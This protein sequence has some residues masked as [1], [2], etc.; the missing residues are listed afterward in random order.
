[1]PDTNLFL[2]FI[3][4]VVQFTAW[5]TTRLYFRHIVVLNAH[6]LNAEGPLIVICNHPNTLIDPLLAVPQL[7]ERP[8]LLANYSMFKHPI[9]R[10]IFSTLFCIPVQRTKDIPA[11]QTPK[12]DEAFRRSVDYLYAGGSVFLAP[13]SLSENGRQ[14]RPFKSGVSRIV[15]TALS[16]WKDDAPPL[17][18]LPVGLTYFNHKKPNTDVIINVGAPIDI[19][20]ETENLPEQYKKAVD[21]LTLI[22][23]NK[24]RPLVIDCAD[25][26]EDNF[27]KKVEC[28]LQN[29]NQVSTKEKFFRSQKFLENFSEK[30]IEKNNFGNIFH[31][32][33]KFEKYFSLLEALH[34][35]DVN[36]KNFS[37]IK[38][39][40]ILVFG[41]PVFVLGFLNNIIP[42]SLATFIKNRMN[43]EDYETTIQYVAGLVLFPI[44]WW[45][46]SVIFSWFFYHP[47][48][49]LIYWCF[50]I[51]T[52]L[53]ARCYFV[54]FLKFRNYLRYKNADK[55]NNLSE[56]RQNVSQFF[57]TT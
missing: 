54:Y 49:V 27:L 51:I 46:Q 21:A 24:M 17:R 25:A 56:I 33:K 44:A 31:E 32:K 42:V 41:F 10:V 15:L 52:G 4:R 55:M 8:F 45:L 2:Q 7:Q 12:N 9:P 14:V 48:L 29:N 35:R 22:I 53:F 39:I 23:E 16:D 28:V 11:G 57:T 13:E 30:N 43:L 20:E 37:F 19:K 47:H 18:I 3:Y 26:E 36:L 5:C 50:A 40:L 1:M 34:L 6:N 38:F